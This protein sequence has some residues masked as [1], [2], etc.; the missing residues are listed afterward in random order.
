MEALSD[1]RLIERYASAHGLLPADTNLPTAIN[2][3]QTGLAA[4][5]LTP[6]QAQDLVIATNAAAKL[7][8]PMTIERLRADDRAATLSGSQKYA[9]VLWQY[10]VNFFTPATVYLLCAFLIVVII[11]WTMH[12]NRLAGLAA[13]LR[14]TEKEDLVSLLDDA[15][16]T[17]ETINRLRISTFVASSA[18]SA[19]S[20]AAQKAKSPPVT[21]AKQANTPLPPPEPTDTRRAD[22]EKLEI[23]LRAKLK[24]LRELDSKISINREA[25]GQ[26]LDIA[27]GE[28][29]LWQLVLSTYGLS[30]PKPAEERKAV[31]A[32]LPKAIAKRAAPPPS[33][34]PEAGKSHCDFAKSE[35]ACAAFSFGNDHGLSIS[36]PA[37]L[38]EA[39]QA[40]RQAES[41]NVLLGTAILPVMYGLLG[42]GVF[43]LR[44]FLGETE[45]TGPSRGPVAATAFLRLGLGGIAGLAIGWFWVP[46]AGADNPFQST[47]FALAFLAGFS[48]E[49]LFSLLDRV[50]NAINPRNAPAASR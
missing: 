31:S 39:F 14:E 1:A 11:P 22:V 40:R 30:R 42:A 24:K 38:Q 46:K 48:I 9:Y 13:E 50:L 25:V 6:A 18:P 49:L 8:A 47:P 36:S 3:A 32:Q 21:V 45:T 23:A 16:Q 27:S 20:K 15:Q 19:A 43:L 4:G 41:L 37:Q 2:Q 5:P 7:I 12:F 44:G 28:P 33:Q 17:E 10:A 29:R 34:A 35:I 26:S